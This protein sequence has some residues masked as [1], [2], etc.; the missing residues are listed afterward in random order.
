M[1]LNTSFLDDLITHQE[2][3]VTAQE[4]LDRIEASITSFQSEVLK[5]LDTL[6]HALLSRQHNNK[7]SVVVPVRTPLPEKNGQSF[8]H[9]QLLQLPDTEMEDRVQGVLNNPKITG[10]VQLGFELAKAMFTEAEFA[11][12]T[13]T[14]R[15]VNG[16]ASNVLDPIRICRI[17]SLVQ[18]KYNIGEAELSAVRSVI[19]DSIAN[20]AKY[21][22]LKLG[23]TNINI[24]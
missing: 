23:Q 19:R 12:S 17:D 21:L 6:E 20:R 15:K 24:L 16:Q 9:Q 3:P 7:P 8:H 13:L 4:Q 18:S 5:R 1:S 14:G 2:S 22:R 10:A 11:T